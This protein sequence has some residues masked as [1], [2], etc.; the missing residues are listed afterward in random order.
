MEDQ[1]KLPE[2]PDRCPNCNKSA[3]N[4]LLHI[5]MK[6]ACSSKIDPQLYDY[7]KREQNKQNKRKY[8]AKY[9]RKGMH[10]EAQSKYIE[11]GKH[12]ISQA[13]Y[14]EK[15]RK[16]CKVCK[17]KRREEC[18]CTSADRQSFLQVKRHNQSKWRNRQIVKCDQDGNARLE[19]FRNFCL[20]VLWCL[21]RGEICNDTKYHQFDENP[22]KSIFNSFHLVEAEVKFNFSDSEEEGGIVQD[23]DHDDT[24]KWLSQVD[25][26]FL[27]LVITFQNVVLVPRSKWIKAIEVVN[28]LDDKKHLK[29]K[30]FRLIGK[31]Q[32]FENEN[33]KGI[34]IPE[35]FNVE[36]ANKN[37]RWNKPSN[38]T[39]EHEELLVKFLKN[40][41]ANDDV[42]Q[43][44]QTLLN[45]TRVV[46]NLKIALKYTSDNV[47]FRI[48]Q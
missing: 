13:K 10:N 45:M 40:I 5:R 25:G 12:K 1:D 47:K 9:V 4:L 19:N 20:N 17:D 36:K 3:K 14:E 38:L 18:K 42:N 43:E 15:F 27:W 33:T 8:Q 44:L 24:H 46:D 37:P 26:S 34:S 2:I 6:E 29:E 11:A 41:V 16:Y 48:L 30:L 39:K 23:Y 32:S 21:K 35:E 22:T 28:T 7:W 31:L